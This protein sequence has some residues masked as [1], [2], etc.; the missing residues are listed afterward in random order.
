M[1]IGLSGTRTFS[2]KD[3]LIQVLTAC[4]TFIIV[5]ISIG[6]IYMTVHIQA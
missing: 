2:D 6:V 1:S 3:G 5:S 4:S